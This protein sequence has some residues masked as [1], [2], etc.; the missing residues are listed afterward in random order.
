MGSRNV[1]TYR[2]GHEAFNRRDFDAMVKEYAESISWIDQARGITFST[3]QEFKDDFLEGW[4]QASSDCQVTHARYT[5]AGEMVVARFTGRGTNDGPLG[6]L[7]GHRQGVDAAD[8]RDV[9]LRRRRSGRRWR[10]LLRPG[11]SAH[12]AGAAAGAVP[13]MSGEVHDRRAP[14]SLTQAKGTS[15]SH[16]HVKP[17]S[18][19]G[20][21]QEAMQ[22]PRGGVPLPRLPARGHRRRGAGLPRRRRRR[23]GTDRPRDADAERRRRA[24]PLRLEPLLARPATGPTART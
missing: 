6:T 22:A 10:D 23:G 2:A 13:S 9:A 3:P 17:A 4:I 20:S 8:L 12:A 19:Y 11:L 16:E 14:P 15:M 21:P 5:D 24:A 18:F 7:P 1:E